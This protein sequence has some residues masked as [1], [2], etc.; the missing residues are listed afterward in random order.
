[1]KENITYIFKDTCFI[2]V[3][4]VESADK[5]HIY[6][7]CFCSSLASGKC[8]SMGRHSVWTLA[9][10]YMDQYQHCNGNPKQNYR[11]NIMSPLHSIFIGSQNAM[12]YVHNLMKKRQNNMFRYSVMVFQDN[13]WNTVVT[14]KTTDSSAGHYP[15]S[16]GHYPSSSVSI[17]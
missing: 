3:C 4:Y 10:I 11:N 2:H 9:T 15:S 6:F 16:A 13:V 7:F 17:V 8:A 1:M 12:L 14:A 5:K